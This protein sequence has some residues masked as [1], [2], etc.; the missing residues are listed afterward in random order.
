MYQLF[1]FYIFLQSVPI[2]HILG[3]YSSNSQNMNNLINGSAAT[4]H[5][6]LNVTLGEEKFYYTAKNDE[7][8]AN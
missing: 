2:S 4:T 3:N 8:I 1:L 5:H 7:K 6:H